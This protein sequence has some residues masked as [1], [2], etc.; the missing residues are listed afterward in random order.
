MSDASTVPDGRHSR[1]KAVTRAAIVAAARE[2]LVEVGTEVSV[3]AITERADVA[4]GSFYNHFDGKPAVFAAAVTDALQ[5]FE[6]WLVERTDPRDGPVAMF[7]ARLRLFGRMTESHPHVAS[8][9][10]SLP[11][12]AEL[13]PHGYSSLARSDVDTAV[14]AGEIDVDDVDIRMIALQGAFR[15]LV[16]LRQRDPSVDPG[17]VDDMVAVFL[18]LFG[19]TRTAANDLA[20]RPLDEVLRPVA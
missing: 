9:I 7:A 5:E 12:S 20:H 15:S 18:E 1:R 16:G 11:P 6:S 19:L 13:A 14:A 10:T 4:L 8:V 2:L 17:R 3:Q